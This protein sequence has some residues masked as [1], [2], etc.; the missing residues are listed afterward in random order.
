MLGGDSGGCDNSKA[1]L[2]YI[3]MSISIEKEESRI[4]EV[5]VLELPFVKKGK[6]VEEGVQ[7]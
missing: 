2:T 7:I 6:A 3:R 5:Y 4:A 1:G